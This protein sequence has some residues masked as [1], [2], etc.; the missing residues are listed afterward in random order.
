MH[1]AKR[2]IMRKK[3]LLLIMLIV[4]LITFTQCNKCK[5]K[6]LGYIQLSQT[7]LNIVPYNE[8]ETLNFK[9]SIG[10]TIQFL[11]EYSQT[12][13]NPQYENASSD[14]DCPGNYYD[15]EEHSVRF[16]SALISGHIWLYMIQYPSFSNEDIQK[17]LF[18]T[19][20]YQDTQYWSFNC[21]FEFYELKLYNSTSSRGSILTFNDSL[22]VG[23]NKYYSVYTLN[24][25]TAVTGYANLKTLY[26]SINNGIIGFKT[27][28]G[29][30]WY[31]DN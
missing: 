27:D 1:N 21:F 13:N 20:E 2:A 29:H 11:G 30:L 3:T 9:D 14:P 19:T 8:T 12:Q 16:N 23:Q 18:I 17:L 25:S 6:K 22:V 24:Q 10:N 15:V 31:L 26:Y 28:Q 5:S 4:T 7:D